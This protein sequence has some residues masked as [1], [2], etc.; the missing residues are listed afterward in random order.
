MDG[1][2]L[3]EAA[4]NAAGCSGCGACPH[5]G[6]CGG[7]RY[8]G[9]D[10][11]AEL[12]A[13]EKELKALFA[14]VT[15]E[16]FFEGPGYGGMSGSPETVGYRNKM[17]YSFGNAE[18]DGPLTLGL[19]RRGSFY[20]VIDV[21]GCRIVHPDFGTIC[22]G[23]RDF[24]RERN[25]PFL[26][27]KTHQGALR[28]LVLRRSSTDGSLMVNLVTGS[29]Y[30]PDEDFVQLILGLPLEGKVAGIL[31]TRNDS[32]GDAVIPE[33]VRLLWGQD[34]L[35]EE[36]LGL[37]FKLSPFSF[38]QTNTRGAELLYS[39]ARDYV[40]EIDGSTVYD[41]YSGTGTIAQV[42]AP[43]AGQVIGV[44][45]VEEAV[46]AARENACL[47][48]LTNCSFIAGDVLKCLDGIEEAPDYIVLDPPRDGVNPKALP[49][50]MARGAGRMVYISC[51]PKSLARDLPALALGGYRLEKLAFVDMFPGTAGCEAIG[52]LVKE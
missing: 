8:D 31:H 28:H 41:L 12:A 36:L 35:T 26:H 37:S 22:R 4:E 11:P 23:V 1:E 6:L 5:F 32:L 19:H 16:G 24:F 27:K 43:A 46:A 14:P 18:K 48:G 30:T 21:E 47:N 49:K 10:Y 33:E 38:F 13:K 42:L 20:D 25:V 50:L 15:A 39:L 51:K 2:K 7:C 44:E 3:C 17:E 9:Q 40:G 45:I 29:A 52:L 34:F